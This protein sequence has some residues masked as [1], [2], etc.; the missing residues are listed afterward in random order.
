MYQYEL[1]NAD[2]IKSICE[3][4]QF[5]SSGEERERFCVWPFDAVS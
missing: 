1:K 2:R 4:V 3:R 5:K